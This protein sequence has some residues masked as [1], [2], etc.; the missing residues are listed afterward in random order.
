MR[1][2]LVLFFS[3]YLLLHETHFG[4]PVNPF[5]VHSIV[6]RFK[7]S[8]TIASI[9][10]PSRC[11]F[12]TQSHSIGTT[13]WNSKTNP[14][15]CCR[16]RTTWW[17]RHSVAFVSM[18]SLMAWSWR[19]CSSVTITSI[20]SALSTYRKE[21]CGNNENDEKG[22]GASGLRLCERKW[23]FRENKKKMKKY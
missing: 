14:W 16:G 20:V 12:E 22:E 18:R 8:A 15:G 10:N 17:R 3:F 5:I 23:Q 4:V 19:F 21:G 11:R 13:T 2:L 6:W 7:C 9:S 1:V